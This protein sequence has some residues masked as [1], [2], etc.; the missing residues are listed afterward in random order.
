M[1]L[2]IASCAFL[3]VSQHSLTAPTFLHQ[4]F[5]INGV[6][7]LSPGSRAELVVGAQPD[8]AP[9]HPAKH[10][11]GCT[12]PGAHAQYRGTGMRCRFPACKC[13]CR[14]SSKATK[15]RAV[16]CNTG[17]EE[18]AGGVY[19]FGGRRHVKGCE[20]T[21]IPGVQCK[22]WLSKQTPCSETGVTLFRH[23][24]SALKSVAVLIFPSQLL[25]GSLCFSELP[26][27]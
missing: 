10:M 14:S 17:S 7:R 22:S 12:V 11:V 18:P 19:G 23:K 27:A 5:L 4:H 3:H 25:R 6:C 13:H 24:C 21:A 16:C 9:C 26:L 15:L 20:G 8:T 1:T 2:F